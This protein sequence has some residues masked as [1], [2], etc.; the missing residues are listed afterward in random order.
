[1]KKFLTILLISL[2]SITSYAQ[3]DVTKF[4]GIPVDGTKSEMIRQLKTKGFKSLPSDPE[5]LTGEFNGEDVYI[6]VITTGNKVSRIMVSDINYRGESDIRI[7]FNTLC[8]QFANNENYISLSSENHKIPADI[9]LSYELNVN[10]KRYETA[11]FQ[12]P[13]LTVIDFD[14]VAAD[15]VS[16]LKEKYTEDEWSE[17]NE[18]LKSE[19]QALLYKKF[20]ELS[21][22]KSVWFM[23]SKGK[24]MNYGTYYINM[25]YDNE[26]NRAHGQDL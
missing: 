16:K 22:K 6:Y 8:D 11:F 7:R 10:D 25:F 15:I 18:E 13:D 9:N 19:Y 12:A 20:V 26:Y 14:A 21:D 4:L 24:G 2:I 23:I 17:K 3:K 5:I 1:M